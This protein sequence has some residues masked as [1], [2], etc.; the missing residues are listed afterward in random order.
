MDPTPAPV[1]RR[2][3]LSTV[4]AA[5]SSA[6]LVSPACALSH[7]ESTAAAPRQGRSDGA[8][9][10]S[11]GNG[12]AAVARAFE[13]LGKGSLPVD[14]AVAGV[15]LNELDPDDTSVGYG[16]LPNEE[17]VVEL[18]SAVMDGTT[19]RAGAVASLRNIKTPS[20]VALQVMRRTDHILLVGEG[21]LRFARA[22]GFQEEDLLTEKS[23]RSPARCSARRPWQALT[24]EPQ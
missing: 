1:T 5:A 24:P 18:D 8:I 6:A 23:T 2:T 3:F 9:C 11:S 10:I 21:A 4:A 22:H 20:R 15:N 7:D 14:A 17:G 16:G 12:K 13:E 19:H